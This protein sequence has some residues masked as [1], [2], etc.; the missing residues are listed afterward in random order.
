MKILGIRSIGAFCCLFLLISNTHGMDL[1]R[2]FIVTRDPQRRI[3]SEPEI[4]VIVNLQK[5]Y[6]HFVSALKTKNENLLSLASLLL[7][8]IETGQRYKVPDSMNEE[9]KSFVRSRLLTLIL[10][11]IRVLKE[12][13]D[14]LKKLSAGDNLISRISDL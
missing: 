1:F 5:E 12:N 2:R 8:Q 9:K 11:S 4:E 7:N 3:D 10:A 13:E 6:Q 14:T